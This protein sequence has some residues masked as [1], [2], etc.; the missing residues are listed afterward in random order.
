MGEPIF[1]NANIGKLAYDTWVSEFCDYPWDEWDDLTDFTKESWDL[2]AEA[3]IE[4]RVV[5]PDNA[6]EV[7]FRTKN[8][9]TTFAWCDA[10]SGQ[11]KDEIIARM[12]SIMS[13]DR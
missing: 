9:A 3:V 7:T 1:I 10:A 4:N 6:F 13:G 5:L 11:M 12:F 8:G 2:V